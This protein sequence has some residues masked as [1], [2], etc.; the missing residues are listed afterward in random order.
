[1]VPNLASHEAEGAD[2][3]L[4]ATQHNEAHGTEH[5]TLYKY[6]KVQQSSPLHACHDNGMSWYVTLYFATLTTY[7]GLQDADC[8]YIIGWCSSQLLPIVEINV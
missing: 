6:N 3:H 8:K 7:S 2:I 1:M 5:K 4:P